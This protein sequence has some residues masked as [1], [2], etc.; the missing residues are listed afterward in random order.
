MTAV[1]VGDKNFEIKLQKNCINLTGKTN[2]N[3][4][5]CLIE[6]SR[7]FIGNDSGLLHVSIALNIKTYGVIGGGVYGT[8]Y[9]YSQLDKTIYF[10]SICD[11]HGCNWE[12]KFERR[13]CLWDIE[14]EI[15][16]NKIV[17][18]ENNNSFD[19]TD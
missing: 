15:I 13:Y 11:Y 14:K 9:P 17:S 1:F 10:Y 12:C 18:A 5:C 2:L 16:I 6:N 19:L 7:F 3:E 8:V 4:V